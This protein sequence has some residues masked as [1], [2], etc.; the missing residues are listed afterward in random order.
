MV[1]ERGEARSRLVPALA[2]K[3]YHS[4]RDEELPDPLGEVRVEVR[5]LADAVHFGHVGC[6]VV[7]GVDSPR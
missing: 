3:S 6:A 5:L 1:P 7:L 4:R 2:V